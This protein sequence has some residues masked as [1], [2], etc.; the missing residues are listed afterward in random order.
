[1]AEKRR[2]KSAIDRDT[3]LAWHIAALTR[4][5]KGLPKLETLLVNQ[6]KR[7]RQSAREQVAMW[8]AFAAQVG[9]HFQPVDPVIGMSRG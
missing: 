6:P 8:Q 5:T 9:G 7:T 3:S 4:G 1:V 2:R